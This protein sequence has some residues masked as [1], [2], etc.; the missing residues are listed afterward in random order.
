MK[1]KEQDDALWNRG[2]IQKG[3]GFTHESFTHL[4]ALYRLQVYKRYYPVGVKND[5]R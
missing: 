1:Q 5:K 2:K 4:Y 3:T